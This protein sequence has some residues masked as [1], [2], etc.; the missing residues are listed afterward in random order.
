MVKDE[1]VIR[2]VQKKFIDPFALMFYKNELESLIQKGLT[3]DYKHYKKL[4][5]FVDEDEFTNSSVADLWSYLK[6]VYRIIP[7][8]L[9]GNDTMFP[10]ADDLKKY[11]EE[12]IKKENLFGLI[13]EHID[14]NFITSEDQLPAPKAIVAS[15]MDKIGSDYA[16][17]TSLQVSQDRLIREI[18]RFIGNIDYKFILELIERYPMLDNYTI[19][20]NAIL[21]DA[22]DKREF[23]LCRELIERGYSIYW[24]NEDGET[25]PTTGIKKEHRDVFKEL[26]GINKEEA[27]LMAIL[28]IEPSG[29]S[30]NMKPKKPKE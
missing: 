26:G 15:Y 11:G 3:T 5:D 20:R 29:K 13:V 10:R 17:W 25:I 22:M 23:D 6:D 4:V 12:Y 1:S 28:Q 19:F 24:Y 18:S 9:P 14:R 7:N 2:A 27:E 30:K 16:E 8:R 21:R